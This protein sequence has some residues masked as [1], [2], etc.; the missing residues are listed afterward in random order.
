MGSK[1]L[2][3]SFTQD[4]DLHGLPSQLALELLNL[5]LQFSNG[6]VAGHAIVPGDGHSA[7]FKSQAA[8]SIKQV[9]RDTVAS[10]NGRNAISAS[11]RFFDY[12]QFIISIPSPPSSPYGLVCGDDLDLRSRVGGIV[13]HSAV[14][15]LR[16]KPFHLCPTVRSNW[17]PLQFSPY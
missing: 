13:R 15:K 4:L 1:A 10:G 6:L 11:Q 14:L 9:W 2:F 3:D 17:G 16:L 7:A 12:A 8:P 5:A